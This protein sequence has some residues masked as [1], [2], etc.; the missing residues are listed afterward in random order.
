MCDAC[1]HTLHMP[2]RRRSVI[3]SVAG[4]ETATTGLVRRSAEVIGSV[5][6]SV[7]VWQCG[8]DDNTKCSALVLLL[9]HNVNLHLLLKPAEMQ[10][11]SYQALQCEWRGC[12]GN[13]IVLNE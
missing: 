8:I 13:D 11:S 1:V 9:N 2:T 10:A 5:H 6:C 3:G 4:I 12:K 7:V